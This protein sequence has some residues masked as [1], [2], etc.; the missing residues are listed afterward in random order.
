MRVRVTITAALVV[1][2]LSI[3]GAAP[4]SALGQ[5]SAELLTTGPTAGHPP[6]EPGPDL[7]SSDARHVFFST[8][9]RLVPEDQDGGCP[10]PFADDP[11]T[12]PKIDCQDVYE[13]FNGQTR[14]V[15]FGANGSFDA[16][17]VGIS[18]DGSKAFLAT[19]EPL[20]PQD[21]D[22]AS[23]IYRWV[24]GALELLDATTPGDMRSVGVS[25]DGSKV[26]FET[27]DRLSP[28]DQNNCQDI[29]VNSEGTTVL[30]ST[31]PNDGPP[32]PGYP[33]DSGAIEGE[34]HSDRALSSPD[35]LHF[36]FYSNRSLVAADTGQGDRDLYERSG[37]ETTLV[38]TGPNAGAYERGPSSGGQFQT[39][40]PD[41]SRVF[42]STLD[43][44]VPED[45]N[46]TFDNYERDSGGVHLFEPEQIRNDPSL[47]AAPVAT[48]YDGS[49]VIL[50][51][52]A[53]LTPDDNDS[54]VDLYERFGG[55]YYLVSTG[56]FDGPEFNGVNLAR[57]E[58]SRDGTRV[59]F[60][61]QQ[62]LSAEDMDGSQDVY[63]RVGGVT[64]LVTP[65]TPNAVFN[66]HW[67]ITPDGSRFFFA[68]LD[69][70]VPQDT[71]TKFDVYEWNDGNVRFV[72]P[73]VPTTGDIFL[74][75]TEG[76]RTVSNDG[77]R[78]IV[79]TTQALTPDDTDTL[80]DLYAL[81]ASSAPDCSRVTASPGMLWPPNRRLRS[82]EVSGASN[83]GGD[84]VSLR[85]TG[86]TQDEPLGHQPDAFAT[87]DPAMIRLRATRSE[88]GDGRVYTIAFTAGDSG[89]SCSGTVKVSVPR[90]R[91]A[92]AVDSAPPSY[93]S[94]NP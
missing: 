58:I 42:F 40:S 60:E 86:V 90:Q 5:D 91:K 55:S 78:L 94:F 46:T 20:V 9:E 88:K 27:R 76:V 56:P 10:D 34:I 84:P 6:Y 89:S 59:F 65:G 81:E 50:E 3:C 66:A 15:S 7:V 18:S 63:E 24:N 75:Y 61:T 64:Y 79:Y 25:E 47:N 14:L 16:A 87:S 12:A 1:S 93:D 21:T 48:S 19:G 17:L 32:D 23:D 51:T 74:G 53:R 57:L 13:R 22:T 77:T 67:A 82:V 41:G 73:G 54:N 43:P 28:E 83:S 62:Q 72:D 68:T 38:S 8:R 71:D 39:A 31:G 36:F 69:P 45:T 52:N 30:V 4:V 49:R 26:F 70:L 37:N 44:L 29:Y 80:V 35:G 92:A 2:S 11:D 33:C 85:V